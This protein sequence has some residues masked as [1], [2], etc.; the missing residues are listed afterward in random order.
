[1]KNRTL[2]N[3]KVYKNYKN[4]FEKI[5]NKAKK[6]YYRIKIKFFE[7]H[8]RGACKIMKEIIG[9]RKYINQVLPKQILVDKI[10][11]NDAKSIAEKFN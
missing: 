3:E 6:N 8:I 9:K 1:M 2:D 5:K 7:N 4:L 11:I 10:E